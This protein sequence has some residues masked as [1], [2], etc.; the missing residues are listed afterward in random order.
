MLRKCKLKSVCS[1]RTGKC[2]DINICYD[3]PVTRSRDL[4]LSRDATTCTQEC[5][6][7]D[8]DQES[9]IKESS[10]IEVK[11]STRQ[12]TVCEEAEEV[13]VVTQR[14]STTQKPVLRCE[15]VL[16]VPLI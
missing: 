16:H 2:E 9:R 13:V 10:C 6:R 12:R 3:K 1:S 5:Q 4:S 11:C 7:P 8:C 14:C 15:E